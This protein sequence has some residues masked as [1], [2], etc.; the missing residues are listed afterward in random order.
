MRDCSDALSFPSASSLASPSTS[1]FSPSPHERAVKPLDV[2]NTASD[3]VNQVRRWERLAA[4]G[5]HGDPRGP[6][7]LC[8]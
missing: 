3:G 6:A 1:P 2:C 7:S 8:A 4:A 5:A